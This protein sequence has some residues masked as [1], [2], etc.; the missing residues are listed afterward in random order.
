MKYETEYFEAAYAK[1]LHQYVN[2]WIKNNDNSIIRITDMSFW[3]DNV[4]RQNCCVITYTT[5]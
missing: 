3:F 2:K 5:N 4:N 1:S